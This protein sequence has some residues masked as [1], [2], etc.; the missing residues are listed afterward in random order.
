M[1][2]ILSVDNMRRS[3]ANTIADGTPGKKL[4]LRAA[5]SIFAVMKDRGLTKGCIAILCG[6]GNNAGDGYALAPMLAEAGAEVTLVLCSDKFSDDGKYYYD[7]CSNQKIKI[8][9]LDELMAINSEFSVI[10]DCL[11]GT[12]FSG[13]PRDSIRKAIS[14]INQNKN[15]TFVISVDINS[16]LNGD[17]GLADI[18]VQSDIT[19]SIGDVKP[20]LYLNMAKDNIGELVNV[21]IGIEPVDKPMYLFEKEDVTMC[22]PKR[23]NDS[24]KGTYGYIALMGGSE[25]YTGAITLASMANS[26]MRSGAGVVMVA[27]PSSVCEKVAPRILESTIYPLSENDGSVILNIQEIDKLIKRVRVIAFG[28]GI[29]ISAGV[30]DTLNY[31]LD[32]YEGILIIDAD[33]LN[34]LSLILKENEDCLIGAACRKIILTPHLK[35]L[36]RL[37]GTSVDEI[38]QKPIDTPKNFALAN[39]CIVLSKGP[40]T[41]VTDGEDIFI[42]DRGCPGMATA[43]SGDVLSGIVAAI[44]GYNEDNLTKA[45]AAAAYVNGY[46]GCLAQEKYGDISMVASDTVGCIPEAIK[47]IRGI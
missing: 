3:D 27:A 13:T 11:L 9:C 40:S 28:M 23:K 16:G 15:D 24:N 18:C 14:Y 4:M 7:Q 5:K 34:V 37:T 47:N 22:L 17:N 46:A 8:I 33:G 39:D 19:I 43:G 31:I 20:G 36:S 21:D 42:V 12:G 1:K 6:S 29:G 26:A 45:V 44:C 2:R 35:E 30:K 38:R 10:V 41:V 25:N 32:H